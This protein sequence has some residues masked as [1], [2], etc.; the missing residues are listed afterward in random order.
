[1]RSSVYPPS[2]VPVYCKLSFLTAFTGSRLFPSSALPCRF[3]SIYRPFSWQRQQCHLRASW[4]SIPLACVSRE[5][6]V[7]RPAAA[8]AAAGSSEE[9]E[10]LL[11]VIPGPVHHLS[12]TRVAVVPSFIPVLLLSRV[13]GTQY[14]SSLC[15]LS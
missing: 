4:P 3:S 11:S 2:P 13:E 15:H 6:V 10:Q 1:M 14:L 12:G 9:T 7:A 5:T 8:A